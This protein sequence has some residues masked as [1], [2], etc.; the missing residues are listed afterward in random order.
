MSHTHEAD[1]LDGDDS[2]T[3]DGGN[4]FEESLL[5]M[6]WCKVGRCWL[7]DIPKMDREPY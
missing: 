2:G 1:Y 5:R 7:V 3:S 4:E 6:R